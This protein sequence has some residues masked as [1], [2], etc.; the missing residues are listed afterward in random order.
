MAGQTAVA[1]VRRR[2]AA[3]SDGSGLFL[4]PPTSLRVSVH[5]FA[6]DGEAGM[7]VGAHGKQRS[8]E[9]RRDACVQ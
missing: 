8:R 7:C 3:L 9:V 4:Q 5:D 6:C 1:H 2:A